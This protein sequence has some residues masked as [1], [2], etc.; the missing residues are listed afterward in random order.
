[1]SRTPRKE[2]EPIWVARISTQEIFSL[3][4]N[5]LANKFS[6]SAN[7]KTVYSSYKQSCGY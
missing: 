2:L 3:Q 4:K 6:F 1:M 7:I 5:L